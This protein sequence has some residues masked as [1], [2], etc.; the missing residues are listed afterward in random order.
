MDLRP[1]PQE[2]FLRLNVGEA[3][4]KIGRSAFPMC[5]PKMDDKP[6]YDRASEIIELS[7]RTFGIPRI[8]V[9]DV[10]RTRTEGTDPLAGLD[11]EGIFD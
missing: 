11:P 4:V 10:P 7:R 3:I 6:N 1:V 5:V 9:T 8:R 2:E